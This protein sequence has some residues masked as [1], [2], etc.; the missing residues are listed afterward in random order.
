MASPSLHGVPLRPVPPLPR[1][2]GTLRIPSDLPGLASFP[3][4]GRYLRHPSFAPAPVGRPSS[5]GQGC[6]PA[7]PTGCCRGVVRAS[8]VPGEPSCARPVL[9]P[10][11]EHHAWPPSL[12]RSA[13]A[14]AHVNDVGSC[15][16]KLSGLY[17]T[18]LH[19][20]CLRFAARV[21]PAPRKTCFRVAANLSR[22]GYFP[23]GSLVRFPL[24][25]HRFLLTQALPGAL[26]SFA[27][28]RG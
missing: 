7:S 22:A 24:S 9:R 28:C 2:Y 10:R 17:R 13:A 20:R 4:R 19:T 16:S 26:T 14:A 5:A 18:A 8:Q 27:V 1:Y 12:R 15:D 11:Q 21:T 25:L 6:C 23:R 3:S